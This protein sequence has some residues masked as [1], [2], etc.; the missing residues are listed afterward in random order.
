MNFGQ[1]LYGHRDP[2]AAIARAR[3]SVAAEFAR[4]ELLSRTMTMEEHDRML[5]ITEFNGRALG[6]HYQIKPH[7]LLFWRKPTWELGPR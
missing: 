3:V 1:L 7:R 5:G 4:V 6:Q 2:E